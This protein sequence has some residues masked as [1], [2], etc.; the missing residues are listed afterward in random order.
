MTER[1]NWFL[2]RLE[3]IAYVLLG[4]LAL[5][6][7]ALLIVLGP[8]LVATWQRFVPALAAFDWNIT[9]ARYAV[10]SIVLVAALVVAHKWLAA[11]RRRFAEI[12]PGI[13]ATLVLWLASGMLF[14][15][16]LAEFPT[17]YVGYYGGLASVMIAL[18]FLYFTSSIFIFGG[19]LN[20]AIERLREGRAPTP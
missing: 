18:V 13:A 1:R 17:V 10:A 6:A 20:A 12:G 7:M 9:L 16:Y 14:G 19:E 11:G 15:R 4:A 2:L 8:V 3:S 5:L